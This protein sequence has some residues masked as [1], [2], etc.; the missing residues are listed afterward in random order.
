MTIWEDL[1]L[2]ILKIVSCVLKIPFVELCPDRQHPLLRSSTYIL[3]SNTLMQE[4]FVLHLSFS[5]NKPDKRTGM[6]ALFSEHST[7]DTNCI[8]SNIYNASSKMGER[9]YMLVH[10]TV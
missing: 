3:R 10:Y 7:S 4:V 2:H 5:K 6:G 1:S 8:K 9:H